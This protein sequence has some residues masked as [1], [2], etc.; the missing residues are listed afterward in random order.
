MEHAPRHQAV[1]TG[2]HQTVDVVLYSDY[3]VIEAQR[4]DAEHDA[5]LLA[6][7]LQEVEARLAL[8]GAWIR[9]LRDAHKHT[10][11]SVDHIS[12]V[13]FLATCPDMPGC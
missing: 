11:S 3:K 9:T 13:E 2:T 5:N 7:S 10:I 6:N 4:G 1:I 12:I 8:A